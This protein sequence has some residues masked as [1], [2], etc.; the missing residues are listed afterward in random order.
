MVTFQLTCGI[1]LGDNGQRVLVLVGAYAL[2]QYRTA[3]STLVAA[4]TRPWYCTAL[5][6]A[7]AQDSTQTWVHLQ[8]DVSRTRGGST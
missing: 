5:R 3:H 1:F 8:G 4:Y 6:T 2:G 7:N